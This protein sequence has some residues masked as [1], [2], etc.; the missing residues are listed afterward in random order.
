RQIVVQADIGLQDTCATP[1]CADFHEQERLVSNLPVSGAFEV[2]DTSLDNAIA[3]HEIPYT[4]V[5]QT[6]TTATLLI[7]HPDFPEDLPVA[8]WDMSFGTHGRV[9]TING[10][11]VEVDA[12]A[13]NA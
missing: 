6:D 2:R 5:I 11:Q 9:E 1:P 10:S 8:V 13:E 7:Y 4:W 12:F 3:W